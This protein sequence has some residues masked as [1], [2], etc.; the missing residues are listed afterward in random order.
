M[1]VEASQVANENTDLTLRGNRHLRYL[2]AP[3]E[4]EGKHKGR[5]T[6]KAAWLPP[7]DL[8]TII[9]REAGADAIAWHTCSSL[10][11]ELLLFG[12]RE[13]HPVTSISY[14]AVTEDMGYGAVS[15]LLWHLQEH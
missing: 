8:E 14:G 9:T 15:W 3:L 4:F 6:G 13:G 10:A 7:N 5:D 11:T 2:S 12:H 1:P